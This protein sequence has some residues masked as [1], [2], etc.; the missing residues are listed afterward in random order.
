MYP[1]VFDFK[2]SAQML[3]S[4]DEIKYLILVLHLGPVETQ[5]IFSAFIRIACTNTHTWFMLPN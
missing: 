1:W 2:R 4:N 5:S 3:H